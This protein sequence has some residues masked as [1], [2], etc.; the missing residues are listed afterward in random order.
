MLILG[1]YFSLKAQ[2]HFF[3]SLALKTHQYGLSIVNARDIG[4]IQIF[5]SAY[6]QSV[7]Y[8]YC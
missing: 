4:W 1:I 8:G 6:V 2:M 5:F 7:R 3:S